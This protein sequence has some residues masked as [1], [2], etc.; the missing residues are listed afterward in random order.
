MDI[1]PV[2]VEKVW[3]GI[4][5]ETGNKTGRLSSLTLAPGQGG[6]PGERDSKVGSS[7]GTGSGDRTG[8]A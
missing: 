2:L 4:K 5:A 1:Q 3:R 7:W 8:G 6:S